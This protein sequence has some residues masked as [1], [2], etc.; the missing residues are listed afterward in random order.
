MNTNTSSATSPAGRRRLLEGLDGPGSSSWPASTAGGCRCRAGT[1]GRPGLLAGCGTAC[2]GVLAR[3]PGRSGPP[4]PG[5]A[6]SWPPPPTPDQRED[7]GRPAQ[8]VA[9]GTLDLPEQVMVEAD[10]SWSR[11]G[12]RLDP[13][14]L[15]KGPWASAAGGR[16][17]NETSRTEQRRGCGWLRPGGWWPSRGVGAQAGQALVAGLAR[18]PAQ[19]TLVILAVGPA[20]GRCPWPSWPA[21]WR[22]VGW[23]RPVGSAPSCW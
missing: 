15:R 6:A 5:S 1:A 10:R 22:P 3:R 4:G 20:A 18:W 17:D 12:G 23:P 2:A 8:V 16:P 14:R 11:R 13:P 19:P 7:L 21:A 9:D